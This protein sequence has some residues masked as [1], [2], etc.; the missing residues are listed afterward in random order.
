MN[1]K[2]QRE[3]EHFAFYCTDGDT[4]ALDDLERALEDCYERV[5]CHL[6]KAPSERTPVHI[7]PDLGTF[8]EAIGCPGAQDWHAGEAGDGTIYMVSPLNPGTVHDYQG[9]IVIAVHEFVHIVVE[10]FGLCQPPYLNEGIACYEAGQ[11]SYIKAWI[12]EDTAR[13]TLPS[14]TDLEY[15]FEGDSGRAYAYSRTYVSFAAET[16]GF[17]KI[18]AQ[19]EGRAQ[20]EVFGMDMAQLNEKWTEFLKGL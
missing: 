4:G 14:L 9:V 7:Y 19:L 2:R 16:F 12:L 6:G 10:Q 13:G 15:I 5:T 18:I 20:T 8:H 11:E 1:Q 3:T 17:D